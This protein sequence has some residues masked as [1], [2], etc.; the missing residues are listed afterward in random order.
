[1]N[2]LDAEDLCIRGAALLGEVAAWLR[3]RRNGRPPRQH[4]E[5]D[6]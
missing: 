3:K 6:G 5:C 1:M 2:R 4:P